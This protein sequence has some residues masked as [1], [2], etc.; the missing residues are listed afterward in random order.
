MSQTTTFAEIAG[1][2][3]LF[4]TLKEKSVRGAAHMTAAAV[5]DFVV[6]LA[7]VSI[8]AR[9]LI[10]E[11]FGLIG[12]VTA[13]TAIAAQVSQLGLAAAT[14]Q[15]REIS[16]GQVSNLFWINV[17]AGLFLCL[18]ISVLSPWIAKF[19]QDPRLVPL[20]IAVST[21]FLWGGLTVQHEA[22]LT[23]QMNLARTA[24]AR[25]AATLLSSVLAVV[26]AVVGY[27]Y[28][29]LV[30]QEVSRSAFIAGGVWL[31]CPWRPG[32]P[33]RREDVR[34][35]LRF[36]TELTLAQFFY[37][38]VSNVD[39]VLVGRLFG[40]D[41]LGIYRQAH[42]MIMVPIEQLN[43]PINSVSQPG[44]SVLQSDPDRYRRY[45]RKMLWIV[46]SVTMPIAAFTAVFAAEIVRVFL[47]SNWAAAVPLL[48]IFAA[49]A[50]IRPVLGTAG[51]V[52]LTSGRSR[53]L[54][55]LTFASQVTLLILIA[56][57]I[58]W[59]AE[60]VAMAYVVTPA[61]LLIPNLYYSFVGT[62]VTLGAFFAA[63]RTPCL[64]SAAMVM[65]LLVLRDLLTGLDSLTSIGIGFIVGSLIYL[66][67]L[68]C[69][70]GGMTELSATLGDLV[71]SLA[72]PRGAPENALASV[73][74]VVAGVLARPQ[75]ALKRIWS[76]ITGVL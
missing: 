30:W 36:G 39:R 57:G 8:L 10:P 26:L 32:L 47:G 62:P 70:P 13:I 52:V 40:A 75:Q 67:A 48:R 42:T 50:F 65:G 49:S 37:A 58:P 14:I 72:R 35:L 5:G 6:R 28:W 44:L 18:A 17:A 54:L 11:H 64:A 55:A 21:S 38:V 76:V 9:L 24:L 73:D 4:G 20:T 15:R 66:L 43:S 19:Y 59:R 51:I 60:G 41:V 3:G 45:Y 34:G 33:S 7:S 12:M 16:H 25:L 71:T 68:L 74:P 22:L 31:L 29:A 23:R 46:S 61:I 69:L 56:A 53:R 63:V 2:S 27:G 1:T